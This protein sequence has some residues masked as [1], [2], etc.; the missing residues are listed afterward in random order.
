MKVVLIS[1]CA[2]LSL[3][4][5]AAQAGEIQGLVRN[6]QGAPVAG[7]TITAV[8]P[9]Q[10]PLKAVTGQDG[11]YTIPGVG[12]GSYTVSVSTG[13]P[14]PLV[15]QSFGASLLLLLFL[16]ILVWSALLSMPLFWRHLYFGWAWAVSG[17]HA[18]AGAD[19]VFIPGHGF[20]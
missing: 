11:T 1:I 15:F 7:A 10:S 2:A 4:S 5:V 18:P 20:W 16:Q 12:S 3:F 8:A 6:A 14:A 9:D 17:T 13:A 19:T